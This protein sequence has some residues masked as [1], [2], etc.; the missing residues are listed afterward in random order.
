MGT[1]NDCPNYSD[2]G[3]GD[4]GVSCLDCEHALYLLVTYK[5]KGI[6][7]KKMFEDH[8]ITVG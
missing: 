1:E 5:R 2:K 3:P 6:S 8:L 4:G 7:R